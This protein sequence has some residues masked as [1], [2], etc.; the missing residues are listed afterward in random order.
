[1]LELDLSP[2]RARKGRETR[3]FHSSISKRFLS[4]IR[5]SSPRT[6]TLCVRNTACHTGVTSQ[7]RSS[8]ARST[9]VTLFASHPI[10]PVPSVVLTKS[11]RRQVGGA[12]PS[13]AGGGGGG[14]GGGAATP[15]S[16][17]SCWLVMMTEFLAGRPGSRYVEGAR[18]S[19]VPRSDG[20]ELICRGVGPGEQRA[21][22]SSAATTSTVQDIL[23]TEHTGIT[24][25]C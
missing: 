13:C 12:A 3:Y 10:S 20:A 1:M 24:L 18:Y 16:R 23:R 14:G 6:R 8:S 11:W 15:L 19:A 9:G 4:Q 22:G 5:S 7:V 25:Q 17:L 21:S 2:G